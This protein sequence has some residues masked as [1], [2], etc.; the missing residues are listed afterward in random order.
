VLYVRVGGSTINLD[1][2][3]YWDEY[4]KTVRIYVITLDNSSTVFLPF[5]YMCAEDVT[6]KWLYLEFTSKNQ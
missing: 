3:A 1:P 2:D 6:D 5:I 4:C